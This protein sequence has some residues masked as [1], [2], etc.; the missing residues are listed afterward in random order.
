MYFL[1]RM[2]VLHT[3]VFCAGK[4]TASISPHA[5]QHESMGNVVVHA[6][7]DKRPKTETQKA[8]EH[9][10]FSMLFDT[11]ST[12]NGSPNEKKKNASALS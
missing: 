4:S 2:Y 12:S 1:P 6:K 10:Q 3:D 11:D 5:S 7:L 8:R 9:M